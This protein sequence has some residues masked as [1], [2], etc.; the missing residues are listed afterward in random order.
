M[1]GGELRC[2]LGREGGGEKVVRLKSVTH[3]Q[4][5]CEYMYV[6]TVRW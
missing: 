6:S 1:K 5:M 2:C 4:L 3:V